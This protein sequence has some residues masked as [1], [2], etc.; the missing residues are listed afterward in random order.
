M[1]TNA[2]GLFAC[3]TAFDKGWPAININLA[4]TVVGMSTGESHWRVHPACQ[5]VLGGLSSLVCIAQRSAAIA[6]RFN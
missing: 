6:L 2:A 1:L 4:I 5:A 3:G